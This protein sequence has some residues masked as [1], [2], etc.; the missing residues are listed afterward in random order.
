M[1]DLLDKL[2]KENKWW[3][4]PHSGFFSR[5]TL[6][7]QAQIL[8]AAR[9]RD[10]LRNVWRVWWREK[11]HRGAPS[12]SRPIYLFIHLVIHLCDYLFI[13][14]LYILSI[15]VSLYHCTLL[16]DDLEVF[17]IFKA[18]II[19]PFSLIWGLINA[20]RLDEGRNQRY[21]FLIKPYPI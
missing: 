15:E 9:S 14:K 7:S 11:I 18:V 20:T 10:W 12:S 21:R 6:R 3:W 13:Y 5:H 8:R 19:L 16:L 1:N 4:I 2:Y 17:I